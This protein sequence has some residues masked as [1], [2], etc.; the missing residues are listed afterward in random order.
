MG[1]RPLEA[2]LVGMSSAAISPDGKHLLIGYGI[3]DP[4]GG[5]IERGKQ[6]PL[7][8]WE[9]ETGKQ[10]RTLAGHSADVFFV[11]YFPN[12]KEAI[13]G[14]SKGE[15]RV[16]DASQGTEA[17][18]F[19]AYTHSAYHAARSI[20]GTRLVTWG[21]DAGATHAMLKLWDARKGKLV[22]TYDELTNFVTSIVLSPDGRTC[23]LT[24]Q[25]HAGPGGIAGNRAGL[26]LWDLEQ[27]T[28]IQLF[29][30]PDRFGPVGAFSP[31]GTLLV[32]DKVDYQSK[33]KAQL[34]VRDLSARKLLREF[35]NRQ[36]GADVGP[37]KGTARAVTF[38][39]DGKH[40]ITEDND[41]MLRCWDL[42]TGQPVWEAQSS[43]DKVLFSPD[44]KQIVSIQSYGGRLH[45]ANAAIRPESMAVRIKVWDPTDGSVSRSVDGMR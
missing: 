7:I 19:T 22:R 17:Q 26:I 34:I 21:V 29:T 1:S 31:D 20:D 41:A 28:V 45:G 42:A 44:R 38:S 8:L 10:V 3:G 39:S 25:G 13:S 16:W 24:T 33:E 4:N 32:L 18:A 43:G 37:A 11:D 30:E 15:F 14:D 5:L 23:L 2:A 6:R 9:L 12:G 35:S 36:G 40:I 27:A